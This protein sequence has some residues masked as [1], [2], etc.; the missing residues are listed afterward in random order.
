LEARKL[1][2]WGGSK[3]LSFL[4]QRLR[5]LH[6]LVR[7]IMFPGYTGPKDGSVLELLKPEAFAV[8]EFVLGIEPL[9]PPAGVVLG[10]LEGEVRD[11]RAHLAAEAARLELQGAPDDEDSAPQRPVGLDPQEAF[12]EHYEARNV[13]DGVGIQIMKLNPVSEK[14]AAEE[15]M[16]GKRQTP[17]QKGDE[18]YPKSRWRPGNDLRA[19][20]ERFR[21]RVLQKAHLLSLGQLLVPDL[22]LNP[23]ADDGGVSISSLGLLGGGAGGGGAGGGAGC[24]GTPFPHG[25]GA[26]RGLWKWVQAEEATAVEREEEDDGGGVG[27]NG[28]ADLAAHASTPRKPRPPLRTVIKE[29]VRTFF[30]HARDVRSDTINSRDV[31]PLG[32]PHV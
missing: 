4:H 26:Q 5:D 3:L 24:G 12:T 7:K 11:I 32:P 13:K 25:L 8:G 23:T 30:I 22:G 14:E 9:R 16:R 27:G 6:L 31:R 2:L 29:T 21:R 20:S 19:S 28:G 18:N 1:L 17:Q 15:R 10:R